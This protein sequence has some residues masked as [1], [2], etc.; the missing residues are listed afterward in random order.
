MVVYSGTDPA[1]TNYIKTPSSN[2]GLGAWSAMNNAG[3]GTGATFVTD[4]SQVFALPSTASFRFTSGANTTA[5]GL[6]NSTC[7]IDLV[8]LTSDY[9]IG[10]RVKNSQSVGEPFI[11]V[12]W[13]TGLNA[14]STLLRTDTVQSAYGTYGTVNWRVL[15]MDGLQPPTGAISVKIVIGQ[16]FQNLN[17]GVCWAAFDGIMFHVG[18][19]L[20]TY[21]D[22]SQGPRYQWNGT[23]Y[24][25]TSTRLA[26]VLA[27]PKGKGGI[28]KITPMVFRATKQNVLSDDLSAYM[29]AGSVDMRT[30]RTIKKL[31]H[32]S[33]TN[34][35]K[36]HA[37]ADYLAP[38]IKIQFADGSIVQ[39][40]LGLYSLIPTDETHRQFG[41]TG[42]FEA[43]DITW[44]LA[45]TTFNL[46]QHIPAGTNI[47]SY[48]KALIAAEDFL[49]NIP[50]SAVTTAKILSYPI[51][52]SKLK[53]INK[54]LNLAG[55]YQCWGDN[56][57]YI[58]SFPFLN[59]KATE[60][61]KIL[62]S[63]KSSEI[64]GAIK[65]SPEYGSI[66]NKVRVIKEDTQN[67]G[68]SFVVNKTNVQP[69]SPTST[70][71]LGRVRM[72]DPYIDNDIPD[73]TTGTEIARN[74]LQEASS[75]HVRYDVQTILDTNRGV[76]EIYSAA[77]TRNDLS[78]VMA[79]IYHVVGWDLP[80][81][82]K[83]PM[84][85]YLNRSEDYQ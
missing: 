2:G 47:I 21:I 69:D 55:Y 26:Q 27:A 70:V 23:I 77:V 57:G 35:T 61:A 41:V 82:A 13:Y 63:G 5:G 42:G 43:R 38:V 84:T 7:N 19:K 10:A 39:N 36:F 31:F 80:M 58:T 29:T 40:Q 85:H 53:V 68:N 76:H 45:E 46:A 52:W 73:L 44:A 66:Y 12:S 71:S 3:A 18:S 25:A 20:T 74:L 65:R 30:D 4:A 37:Y 56:K 14:S 67:P 9:S 8:D 33:I 83:D 17:G 34:P 6:Q 15:S 48:A 22:G 32:G 51:T 49:A 79:G 28:A 1:V 60:P 78:P 75:F 11:S 50:N 64:V 72:M 16:I 62:V 81:N 54:L 59:F 24:N